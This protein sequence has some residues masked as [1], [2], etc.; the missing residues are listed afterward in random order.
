MVGSKVMFNTTMSDELELRCGDFPMFRGPVG[1]KQGNIAVKIERYIPP[2][3]DG[4]Q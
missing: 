1:Q 3:R 4:D 2:E